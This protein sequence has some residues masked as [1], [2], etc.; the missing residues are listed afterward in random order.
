M[1][2][3]EGLWQTSD[4]WGSYTVY[5]DDPPTGQVGFLAVANEDGHL[6]CFAGP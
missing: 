5:V 2:L 1:P 6:S 3:G 4:G